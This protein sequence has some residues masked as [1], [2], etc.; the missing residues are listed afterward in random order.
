MPGVHTEPAGEAVDE[1]DAG[2]DAAP[3]AQPT[4]ITRSAP[5][6]AAHVR[7]VFMRKR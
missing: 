5:T 7:R 6:Q 1:D 4:M 3:L 2:D